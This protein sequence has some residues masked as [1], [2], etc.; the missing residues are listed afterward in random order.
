MLNTALQP[1]RDD[2]FVEILDVLPSDLII[3]PDAYK[4]LP[5]RGKVLSLGPKQQDIKTGEVVQFHFGGVEAYYPNKKHALVRGRHV[6]LVL[7]S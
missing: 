3:I 2:V 1:L 7:E 4:D 5:V 6:Q